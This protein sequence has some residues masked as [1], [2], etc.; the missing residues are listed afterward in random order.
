MN[1]LRTPPRRIVVFRALMLGDLLCATPALR[2]LDRAFPQAEIALVGLPWAREL[3]ERLDCVD[4]FIAFPGFPGL[5]EQPCD[6]AR[7]PAFLVEV[8]AAGFDL[9]VQLHGSGPVCNPLVAAFGAKATAGFHDGR[10]WYPRSDADLWRRWPTAG[11]EIERLLALTDH[12]GLARDGTH[13]DFPVTDGDRQA[14]G[15]LWPDSAAAG[16]YVCVH[17][18]AQLPSRRWH[19]ERFAEVADGLAASGRRVALTGTAAEAELCRDVQQR[20]R[21]P[22][23]DLSGQTNL[24]TLGALIEGAECVVCNDTGIS[25]VAS[26]L[27]TPSVVV[28]CGSDVARWAPLDRQRHRVLWHDMPCRP[29]ARVHCPESHG[30]AAGVDV[31]AV[32]RSAAALL[33]PI[34]VSV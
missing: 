19:P 7:L 13:L 22:A 32:M 9:A 27:G 11:H 1:L 26:A 33:P 8:Q 12:L 10:C 4:R 5:P 31:A 15:R 18:G 14:L 6:V 16:A 24:W 23:V 34:P 30:C 20:M 3:V 21:L 25:H 2:A 17:V 29:C 28:A